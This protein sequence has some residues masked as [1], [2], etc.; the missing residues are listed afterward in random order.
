MVILSLGSDYLRSDLD[1]PIEQSGS[2]CDNSW[3][4]T[5]LRIS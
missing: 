4:D 2:P 5:Y 1:V 3:L